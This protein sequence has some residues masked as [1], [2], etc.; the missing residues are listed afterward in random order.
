VRII[1]DAVLGAGRAAAFAVFAGEIVPVKKPDPAIY[2]LAV[3]QLGAAPGEAV[4]VEDSRIGLL[5]AT[6]AGLP[7]VVTPSSFTRGE[8]FAEAALVVTTLGDPGEPL[9]VLAN[10]SAAAP[11][12]CVTLADVAALLQSSA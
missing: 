7:C 9:E 4:V 11:D 8:D 1:L 3:E 2:R 6:G 5:A 12:G 10:R